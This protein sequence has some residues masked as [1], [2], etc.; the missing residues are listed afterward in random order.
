MKRADEIMTESGL[1][2]SRSKARALIEAGR[3]KFAGKVVDK[4]SRK[5]PKDAVL[6]IS[7]DAPESRYVSRAGLK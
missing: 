4:P 6:E 7:A 2:P 1:A 5:L 3:V